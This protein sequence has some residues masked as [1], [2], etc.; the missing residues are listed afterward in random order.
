MKYENEIKAVFGLLLSAIAVQILLLTTD[1][2][3]DNFVPD[4]LEEVLLVSWAVLL[5]LVA[6]ILNKQNLSK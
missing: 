3:D 6:F 5:I 1:K 2:F 4:K